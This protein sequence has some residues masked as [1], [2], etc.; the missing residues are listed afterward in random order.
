MS[1]PK[2]GTETVAAWRSGSAE[3]VPEV[4][5]SEADAV[6]PSPPQA[7]WSVGGPDSPWS[8]PDVPALGPEDRPRA[9]RTLPVLAAT[10]LLALLVAG[11]VGVYQ[12]T[13]GASAPSR[14]DERVAPIA[15]RVA[16]L[17]GL[18]FKH[19][20]KVNY[21]SAKSFEKKLTISPADL[22]K[23]RTEIDQANGLLR[24]AGLFGADVDI[25]EELNTARTADTLAFY[26]PD[27]KQVFIRGTGPFTIETRVTLAHELTHVL[28]DQ[29]FDLP[30]LEKRADESSSGSSDALRALIEGDAVRIEKR[31][32]ADQS[33]TDRRRYDQLSSQGSAQA[34]QRTQDVPAVVD[35]FF[36]APYVF[37]PQ[38]TRVLEIVD[39]NSGIDAALSG[40]TPSTRIYFDPTAV[41]DA[42][43]VP[44]VPALRAGEE[45]IASSSGS[46][47]QFDDFTLYLMLAARME[48]PTALRAADAYSAGSEVLY[49]RAG[50]TCFRASIAGRS[51]HANAYLAATLRRWTK[52]M[53]AARI[54]TT[55]DTT[56]FESCD[57]GPK[58]ETPSDAHI[59]EAIALAAGRNAFTATIADEAGSGVLGACVARLLVEY[60][61]FRDALVHGDADAMRTPSPLML[62][63]SLDAGSRCRANHQAGLP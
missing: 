34:S 13:G 63:E 32:L 4:G 17:R 29:H 55:A 59:R 35:S 37:G 9:N 31:Y 5:A 43:A 42:P 47:D 11:G 10:F 60:A 16:A 26:D 54:D 25:A 41:N 20:V 12:L 58:A 40:P 23:E 52:T 6:T 36:S 15:E 24:A 2:C 45:K 21:L 57:P 30:K 7:T 61:D 1:C 19:P 51:S 56:V 33:A 38:V 48:R 22:T 27:S 14:W 8:P 18:A 44:P 39:G 28:Q 49:T 62:S 46:D 50:R 53:P 3:R